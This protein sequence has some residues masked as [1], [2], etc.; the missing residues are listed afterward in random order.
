M[1]NRP[2][3]VP[4]EHLYPTDEWRLI[5]TRY[6]DRYHARAETAMA[7]SNGYIGIRGT[8]DEGRPSLCPGTFVNGFHE[9]WPIVHAEEAYGLART[10][11]T[12]IDAPDATV[13]RLYVDD[14]PLF[15]RAMTSVV[16]ATDGFTVVGEAGS[17]EESL[18]KAAALR[19]DLVL[20]DVNLPGIDGLEAARRMRAGAP[21]AVVVLLSTYD[22]LDGVRFVAESGAAAYVTKSAFGPDRLA[23]AWA[24]ARA[25]SAD[26]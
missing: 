18:D 12:I 22:E 5:E 9:T 24:A 7:L 20:M 19:P 11:Q 26:R 10:G 13:I 21:G 16:E 25:S 14:E 2:L 6:S 17:G 23:A 3:Q 4:P 8:Y 15:R 1:L